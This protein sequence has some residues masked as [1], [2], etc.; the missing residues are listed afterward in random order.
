M[1]PTALD[2]R[3]QNLIYIAHVKDRSKIWL[4]S[5]EVVGWLIPSCVLLV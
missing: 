4:V 2:R 1:D 5:V 3:S